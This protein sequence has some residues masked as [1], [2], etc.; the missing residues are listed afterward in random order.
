VG[1]HV[2]IQTGAKSI[3]RG[4]SDFLANKMGMRGR[5]LLNMGSA[6]GT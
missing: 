3:G 4:A 2:N 1:E 5:Q 6:I